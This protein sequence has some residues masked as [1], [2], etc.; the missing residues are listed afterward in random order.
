MATISKTSRFIALEKW[1]S[2]FLIYRCIKTYGQRHKLVLHLEKK[3][4][5]ECTAERCHSISYFSI[6]PLLLPSPHLWPG[7]SQPSQKFGNR[8]AHNHKRESF[9]IV[10]KR[11]SHHRWKQRAS[12]NITL[13]ILIHSI[14]I[15]L[16]R[17]L[18]CTERPVRET[19]WRKDELVFNN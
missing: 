6:P 7:I 19:R 10:I 3:N 12:L 1:N 9:K 8:K 11:W 4:G 2:I 18:S 16:K 5:T 17:R 13:D 15:L 14:E